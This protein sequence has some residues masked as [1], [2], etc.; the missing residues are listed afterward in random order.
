MPKTILEKYKLKRT[1]VIIFCSHL[2]LGKNICKRPN[3]EN[4]GQL[5]GDFIHL[6]STKRKLVKFLSLGDPVSESIIKYL[7]YIKEG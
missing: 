7:D 1:T 4:F 2:V 3:K 6:A 5:C